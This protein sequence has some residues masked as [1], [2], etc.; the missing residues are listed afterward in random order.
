[1]ADQN[2][3]GGK[4]EGAEGHPG[5]SEQHQTTHSDAQ[6]GDDVGQNNRPAA[7]QPGGP[8]QNA[9]QTRSQNS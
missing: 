8:K 2:S 4:K 6:P 3:R 9:G 1:M 7:G 5:Q